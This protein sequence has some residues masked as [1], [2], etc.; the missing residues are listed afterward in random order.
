MTGY[1]FGGKTYYLF[2][3]GYAYFKLQD[4]LGDTPLSEAVLQGDFGQMCDI[5]AVLAEQ[6][7]LYRRALGY[8]RGEILAADKLRV[9]ASPGE[10]V[11]L[12]S[13][14]I[15]AINEGLNRDKAGKEDDDVDLGLAELNKKK[16]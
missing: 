11:A 6:G 1:D 13:A 7:E 10:G 8:D 3:N 2:Y 16:G 15:E 4:L 5:A 12:R 9:L 14:I